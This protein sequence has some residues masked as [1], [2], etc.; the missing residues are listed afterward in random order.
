MNIKEILKIKSA[1][2]YSM[3][4]LDDI[5]IYG[6]LA[7][8][9]LLEGISAIGTL[10]FET[11]CNES[12]QISKDTLGEI[13]LLINQVA[14]IAGAVNE[15]MHDATEEMQKRITPPNQN[16]ELSENNLHGAIGDINNVELSIHQLKSDLYENEPDTPTL[17]AQLSLMANTLSK[18]LNQ[19]DALVK[20][21]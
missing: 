4:E 17:Y 2:N 9:S 21:N 16:S 14:M 12:D 13:G 20:E 5:A 1:S 11:S 10:L 15:N 7:F 18:S 8:S 6:E 3:S 19:L